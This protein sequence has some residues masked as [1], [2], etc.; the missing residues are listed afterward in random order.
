MININSKEDSILLHQRAFYF[1]EQLLQEIKEGRIVLIGHAASVMSIT[2]GFMSNLK[3][4]ATIPYASITDLSWSSERGKFDLLTFG[5]TSHLSLKL[6]E[7]YSWSFPSKIDKEMREALT[8]EALSPIG[9]EGFLT[10]ILAGTANIIYFTP[11][12]YTVQILANDCLIAAIQFGLTTVQYLA[13]PYLPLAFSKFL[14]TYDYKSIIIGLSYIIISKILKM[15]SKR[16]NIV[17][18]LHAFFASFLTF[19]TNWIIK[20]T[21]PTKTIPGRD[22]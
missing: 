4:D 20:N 3:L 7:K 15:D 8:S 14:K 18:F 12:A 13:V 17:K 6:H 1:K 2:R 9:Y 16:T 5:D 19:V 21:S 10:Y 11:E 22:L